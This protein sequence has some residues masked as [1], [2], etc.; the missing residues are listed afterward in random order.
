MVGGDEMVGRRVQRSV[1]FEV[2]CEVDVEVTGWT[3]RAGGARGNVCQPSCERASSVAGWQL[4]GDLILNT[5]TS[6]NEMDSKMRLT[7][8]HMDEEERK[9]SWQ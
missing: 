8:R 4:Q 7:T 5:T 6:T 1:R 3:G 2:T 9:K